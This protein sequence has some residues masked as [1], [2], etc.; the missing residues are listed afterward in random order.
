MRTARDWTAALGLGAALGCGSGGGGGFVDGGAGGT[1]AAGGASAASG[2]GASAGSA[3]AG[4][5][6]GHT[7]SGDV[8]IVN[9]G[10]GT[11]TSVIL[12]PTS[13][14]PSAA[15]LAPPPGPRVDQ[16]TGSF[17]IPNVPDGKYFVLVAWENDGLVLDPSTALVTITVAG[18][19]LNAG[20]FKVTGAL[21]IVSP[22]G[23][24]T[25]GGSPT[26]T[27]QDDAGEDHYELRL[28]DQGGALVHYD[29]QIPGVTGNATVSAQ[30]QGPPLYSGMTYQFQV[31]SI[32]SSGFP[33]SRTENLRGVFV[34][35]P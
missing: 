19:D 18:G 17:A 26:F 6:G 5:G 4:G 12:A 21:E 25:V 23:G 11:S 24:Q 8:Q 35:A 29:L 28:F 9:P 22:D 10:S 15:S 1:G 2:S 30:Y 3:G 16:V 7:V 32:G 33:L 31:T 20:S 14:E 34:S 13:F 27:W